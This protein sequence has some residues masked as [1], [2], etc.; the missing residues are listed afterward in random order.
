MFAK[1]P[2]Q[3]RC[4]TDAF[5]NRDGSIAIESFG[6]PDHNAWILEPNSE[7]KRDSIMYRHVDFIWWRHHLL[8]NLICNR[9]IPVFHRHPRFNDQQQLFTSELLELLKMEVSTNARGSAFKI[10]L[11]WD[12]WT[13]QCRYLLWLCCRF[14]PKGNYSYKMTHAAWVMHFFVN[15]RPR[16]GRFWMH[17]G[18]LC[19]FW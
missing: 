1:W 4:S 17:R 12:L 15:K 14:L 5:R 3:K 18:L 16:I 7:L 8:R 10:D 6:Y 11:S 19:E 9:L 2:A 13:L